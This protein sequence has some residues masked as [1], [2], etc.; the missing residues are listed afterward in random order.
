MKFSEM[1]GP[2]DEST[3]QDAGV[4]TDAGAPPLPPLARSAPPLPEHPVRLGGNR[5]ALDEAVADLAKV[6]PPEPAPVASGPPRAFGPPPGAPPIP[7]A[8]PAPPAVVAA[9]EAEAEEP[10]VAAATGTVVEDSGADAITDEITDE[11][12]AEPVV[13]PVVEPVAD[14]VTDAP[15]T[16]TVTDEA[17]AETVTDE[18][19]AEVIAPDT[20]IEPG[21][22]E[23]D[24]SST[25]RSVAASAFASMAASPAA[26]APDTGLD[27]TGPDVADESAPAELLDVADELA[28]RGQSFDELTAS[29]G[30]LDAT[31][32]LEGLGSIDDDMLPR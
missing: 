25:R 20:G 32:W 31:S 12:A 26:G 4:T 1:M 5:S 8:P 17:L 21:V 3:E 15:V 22:D 27:V 30:Q 19:T 9:P 6:T 16:E 7:P 10:A 11:V 14:T 24:D 18:P 23:V 2:D 13:E 28:S 29:P